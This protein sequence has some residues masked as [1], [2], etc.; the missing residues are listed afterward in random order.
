MAELGD[1][2]DERMSFVGEE[3]F[4]DIQSEYDMTDTSFD[5]D[6]LRVLE[7]YWSIVKLYRELPKDMCVLE[8]A[9]AHA[10]SDTDLERVRTDYFLHLKDTC[11]NFPFGDIATL[12]RRVL[13]RNGDPLHVKLAQDIYC[14]VEVAE[15]G[16]PATLKPLISGG[17]TKKTTIVFMFQ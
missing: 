4:N 7:D 1:T 3:R 14:I 11:P 15:G 8:I 6:N 10:F 5:E 16:D 13:T 9:R 12:K 2:H 17:R